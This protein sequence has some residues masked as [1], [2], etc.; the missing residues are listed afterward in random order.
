LYHCIK[1]SLSLKL[2]HTFIFISFLSTGTIFAQKENNYLLDNI[3]IQIESTE[4]IDSMYNFNFKEAEKQFGWIIQ[5][6]PEHP[7]GYFLMSLSHWWKLLPEDHIRIYDDKLF[8]YFDKTIEIAKKTYKE[9]KSNEEMDFFLAACYGLKARV[10]SDR[11]QYRKAAS[12]ANS[13][14]KYL[15][16]GAE[17]SSLSPEF[18]FGE[19]LYNYFRVWIPEN[20]TF[21]KPIMFFFR[22]GD[23]ELGIEQLK[24]ASNEAFY[25]RI[26]AMTFMMKIYGEYEGDKTKDALKKASYLHRLYPNNP[27]FELHYAKYFYKIGKLKDCLTLSE[28]ILSKHENK[29]QGYGLQNARYA[30]YFAGYVSYLYK[31]KDKAHQYFINCVAHSEELHFEERAY[32]RKSLSYL[33][34]IALEN[35]NKEEAKTYYEKIKKYG[36][37]K[38]SEYKTAKD[39]LRKNFKKRHPRSRQ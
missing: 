3:K 25:T 26:E 13:A 6:H 14:L 18:L 7:L 27:Y 29:K 37:K 5:A 33:A 15:E 22:K 12:A 1:N 21:L 35:N 17:R 28:D 34:K 24:Q 19:G 32:Y 4:A 31:K 16:L 2:I 10:F 8:Y 9:D 23:K 30:S 36:D 38:S 20:K 39:F 11:E